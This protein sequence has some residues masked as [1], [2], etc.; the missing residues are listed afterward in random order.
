MVI[1][2]ENQFCLPIKVIHF[3]IASPPLAEG[4]GTSF[5]PGSMSSVIN[6]YDSVSGKVAST[7]NEKKG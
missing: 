2:R 4:Y 7:E 6:S 5:P 1:A 3:I